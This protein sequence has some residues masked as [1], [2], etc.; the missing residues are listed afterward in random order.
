MENASKNQYGLLYLF[1][2][3]LFYYNYISALK[4]NLIIELG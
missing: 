4:A 3:M 1:S 2:Y